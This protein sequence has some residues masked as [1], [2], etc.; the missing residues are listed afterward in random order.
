MYLDSLAVAHNVPLPAIDWTFGPVAFRADAAHYWLQCD[1]ELWDAQ[2]VPYIT[3]AKRHGARVESLQVAYSHPALM[4]K[5][6]EYVPLWSEKRLM[7]LN[8]IFKHFADAI[9]A[10]P[11]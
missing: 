1:G 10:P 11:P 3:A 6:E 5:E 9:K 7:Q 2:V 4:K 8:F